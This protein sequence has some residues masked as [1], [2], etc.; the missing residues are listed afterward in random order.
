MFAD[1]GAI[2]A[3]GVDLI[4]TAADLQAVAATLPAA[5]PAAAALG[6]IG[7]DFLSALTSAL[8]DAAHEATRLG[9]DLAGAADTAEATAAAYVDTERRSIA[10]LGG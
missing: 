7:A 2:G 3:A 4:R 10:M 9:S 6:P 1:T 8:N 5:G